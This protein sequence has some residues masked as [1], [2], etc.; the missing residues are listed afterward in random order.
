MIRARA[1]GGG[2]AGAALWA[3]EKPEKRRGCRRITMSDKVQLPPR[4]CWMIPRMDPT[5][6][7]SLKALWNMVVDAARASN[8]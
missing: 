6:V 7:D 2:W 1:L 5:F 8:V 4:F 3:G